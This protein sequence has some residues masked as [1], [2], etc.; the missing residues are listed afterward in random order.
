VLYAGFPISRQSHLSTFQ[1]RTPELLLTVG[2]PKRS[3]AQALGRLAGRCGACGT[4]PEDI[5]LVDAVR[6]SLLGSAGRAREPQRRYSLQVAAYRLHKLAR[7]R[8]QETSI[9]TS[10]RKPDLAVPLWELELGVQIQRVH[11]HNFERQTAGAAGD[12]DCE[13][14]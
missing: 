2:G 8:L 5:N 7:G 12:K 10:Q 4:A 14:V 6:G 11:P 1:Q 9:L 13:V 3:E